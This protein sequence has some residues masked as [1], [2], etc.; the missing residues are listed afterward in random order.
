MRHMAMTFR[1]PLVLF[2]HL[3]AMSRVF[4]VA[5]MAERLRR[6]VTSDD[7]SGRTRVLQLISTLVSGVVAT[8]TLGALPVFIARISQAFDLDSQQAGILAAADLGGCAIGC[9]ACLFVQRRL[10][11]RALLVAA[12]VVSALGSVLS[13]LSTEYSA[14]LVSRV[15]AGLGNGVIVSLVFAAL[16]A[17]SNP[18]R[19]FGLYTFGQLVAQAVSIPA[20]ASMVA[21]FGI[22]AI[23]VTLTLL[24][25]A[26]IVIVPFFPQNRDAA[27]ST[28]PAGREAEIAR[29]FGRLLQIPA[30]AIFPLIG[31]GLYFAG[32]AAVWAFF[33]PIGQSATLEIPAIAS[34]LGIASL[35]GILGPLSVL[36][37]QPIF[38]RMAL[39]GF[40]TLLHSISLGLLLTTTG[41]WS[42]LCAT[43]LFIFSLNFVFPFQMGA[44]SRY[45]QDGSIA[46]IA[47]VLQLVCLALGPALGGFLYMGMGQGFMLVCVMI[48]FGISVALF[49]S[50]A[51]A[52]RA[53]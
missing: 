8:L 12:I 4:T 24:S 52:Q 50:G 28:S 21:Q 14:V 3:A 38:N 10:N 40:G 46:I 22:D 53:G 42:F 18:D 5:D 7:T 26:L 39:L 19:S 43:S 51:R 49:S 9:V 25:T 27:D 17:S 20:F 33:D 41:F 6:P 29:G 1:L 15:I 34:A 31:L 45:D 30:S 16:S 44:L 11:W 48:G 13:V 23:F 2:S 35:I 47:L 36:L 37:L 32:F